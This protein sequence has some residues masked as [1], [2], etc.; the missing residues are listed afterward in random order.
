[1]GVFSLVCVPIASDLYRSA[2]V[3]IITLRG[4]LRKRNSSQ[5]RA[6]VFIEFVWANVPTR[7]EA[8]RA[9]CEQSPCVAGDFANAPSAHRE[10][11]VESL[12]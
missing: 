9:C 12:M 6:P 8:V 11:V 4:T 3:S 2:F 7:R 10:R 1:M 5:Q